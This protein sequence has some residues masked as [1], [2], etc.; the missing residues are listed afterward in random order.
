[1]LHTRTGE[2]GPLPGSLLTGVEGRYSKRITDDLS[3]SIGDGLRHLDRRRGASVIGGRNPDVEVK[4]E[5]I[6]SAAHEALL[7]TSLDWQI[8][9][10]G[11]RDVGAA[12]FDVV[13]PNLFF[14]K[15]FGD[16]PDSLPF[17]R[18]LALTGRLGV[19]IPTTRTSRVNEGD[20]RAT[21]RN[22]DLL[23][24]GLVVEYSIPYLQAIIR[25]VGLSAPFN[26]LI[27]VVELDFQTPLDRKS[28]PTFGTVNPGVV[29]QISPGFQVAVEAVVPINPRTST[30]VGVR[31]G[32]NFFLNRLVP[33][34]VVGHP[35][36]Q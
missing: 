24:W 8:G 23:D 25:K 17:L 30:D 36:V 12:S 7:S 1:M 13:E 31:I 3:I 34:S 15:G 5:L 32:V 16:L 20:T 21:Q 2:K 10:L 14:A 27:P 6:E 19:A 26:K 9:G 11:K 35:L 18:P 28:H 4:Y 22:A 29:W 33:D